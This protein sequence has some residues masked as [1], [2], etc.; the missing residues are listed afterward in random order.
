MKIFRSYAKEKKIQLSLIILILVSAALISV[1]LPYTS[2]FL[3][4]DILIAQNFWLIK[5]FIVLFLVVV[6]IQI[7]I[8]RAGALVSAKFIKE[9][10]IYIRSNLLDA[11]LDTQGNREYQS[12]I[13]TVI[14]NDVELLSNSILSII[15][16]LVG[17]ITKLIGFLLIIT[18]INLKL[19]GIALLF[20]PIYLLWTVYVSSKL[21]VL[22]HDY[23]KTKENLLLFI[24]SFSEN[25]IPIR[26]YNLMTRIK[27]KY[28]DVIDTNANFARKIAVYNN[29]VSIISNMIITCANFVPLFI[30]IYFVKSNTISLGELIAFNSYCSMLFSPITALSGL[31]TLYKTA[32]VYDERIGFF[33]LTKNITNITNFNS[34]NTNC[35]AHFLQITELDLFS[36]GER[37]LHCDSF[38][39]SNGDIVKVNGGNGSGKSLFLQSICGLYKD[40]QG[41]VSFCGQDITNASI[42]EISNKI[43]YV[44]NT[45]N[46]YLTSLREDLVTDIDISDDQIYKVLDVLEIGEKVRSLPQG[47]STSHE[48]LLENISSGE[49]QILKLAR[50]IIK[51]PQVIILDEMFSNVEHFKSIRLLKT[52]REELSYLTIILVEH[53]FEGLKADKVYR[54]ENG[55]LEKL[56]T[57]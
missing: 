25:S 54:I 19:T 51:K 5:Y 55:I 27:T 56:N 1:P 23:Q 26:L 48:V 32:E 44:S 46:L 31:V 21:K 2:K 53:H 42:E 10:T 34:I 20:C 7:I 12:S 13:Q 49:L 30:G 6:V 22:S 52:I 33:L 37:I 29:Y 16:I 39:I 50:A 43:L 35:S 57:F 14:I 18:K 40:F 11:L 45:Q 8:G 3:I 24:K 38:K 15:N 28:E 4:D 17:N 41:S 47:L 9:F 36:F